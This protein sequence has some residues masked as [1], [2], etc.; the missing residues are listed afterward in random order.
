MK[1]GG[2]SYNSTNHVHTSALF[3]LSPWLGICHCALVV[4]I[5]FERVLLKSPPEFPVV[6]QA[7]LMQRVY[8]HKSHLDEQWCSIVGRRLP[9]KP[10]AGLKQAEH[11]VEGTVRA[12]TAAASQ[13]CCV[14]LPCPLPGW[15][16]TF[17]L[18]LTR[19]GLICWKNTLLRGQMLND[20][21]A[22]STT[23]SRTST[24]SLDFAENHPFNRRPSTC[25]LR[26]TEQ[27]K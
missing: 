20:H 24:K 6:G 22:L 1:Q 2:E 13:S 23:R 15:C 11:W 26:C 14:A 12:C 25:S 16:A 7:Y 19:S 21:N 8:G 4:I 18:H 9:Y 5:F 10:E 3:A 27:I 17:S